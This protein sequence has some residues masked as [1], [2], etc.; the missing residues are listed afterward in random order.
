MYFE[1]AG[2]TINPFIPL[3]FA[4][5]ISVFT[6]S[7][8]VSG[9]FLILPFQVSVLGFT[10][11]AVSATNQFYN[12]IA[13]PSGVYRY[14]KEGRMLLP[15]TINVIVG[16][17]PGVILGALIRINYFLDPTNFKFFAGLV[18]FYIGFRLLNE[19]ILKQ[20]SS[21]TIEME[22]KFYR[23]VE[24]Y[25]E[26]QGKI[27]LPKPKIIKFNL[28]IL[29]FEFV[30]VD[31]RVK[32]I[33]IFVI[34]A[35]VGIIGGIYGIGGG[36]IMAPIYVALFDLPVYVVAGP[37]LMGTFITSLFGTIIYQILS[38]FY[39]SITIAPDW[40]LGGL[41]GIGGAIGMYIGA[42]MQKFMPAKLIK[43]ILAF[44]ILFLSLKYI[45]EF[46][47]KLLIKT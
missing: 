44:T 4:F 27:K 40:K 26:S 18:L 6:S 13:I 25:R 32:T 22:Q 46:I 23:A 12:V 2:I 1:V 45:T 10:S 7:G 38:L 5:L 16:T 9:A 29:E 19:I 3:L 8:G 15:L 39:H 31:F 17:L 43:S 35:V 14:I 24:T 28:K 42:R 20:K 33:P 47:C 41:F 34:S 37:A 11:P 21:K 36:A 30:G